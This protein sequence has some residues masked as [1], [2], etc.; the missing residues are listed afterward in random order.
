MSME[1]TLLRAIACRGYFKDPSK[2]KDQQPASKMTGCVS[3]R[4]NIAWSCVQ[5]GR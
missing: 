4:V 1:T 2:K 3:Q 5:K